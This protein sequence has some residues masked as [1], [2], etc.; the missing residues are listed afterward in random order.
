VLRGAN[1]GRL[2]RELCRELRASPV[3][4]RVHQ[5]RA[6]WRRARLLWNELSG[7]PLRQLLVPSE[8]QRGERSP[9]VQR[10]GRLS[11]FG[12]LSEQRRPARHQDLHALIGVAG[13]SAL[14]ELNGVFTNPPTFTEN[15]HQMRILFSPVPSRYVPLDPQATVSPKS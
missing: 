5:T 14:L 7:G 6:L 10:G 3:S 4:R 13:L 1:G 12:R 8:L 11:E 9:G 2:G 15:P